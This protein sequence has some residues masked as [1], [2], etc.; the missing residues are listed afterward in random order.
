MYVFAVLLA[1]TWSRPRMRRSLQQLLRDCRPRFPGIVASVVSWFAIACCHRATC[2]RLRG[3]S[4]ASRSQNF[5]RGWA[6]SHFSIFLSSPSL[7]IPGIHVDNSPLHQL[8]VYRGLHSR[9]CFGC[10]SKNRE[11]FPLLRAEDM[12]QTQSRLGLAL[13][14]SARSSSLRYSE[15]NLRWLLIV[16]PKEINKNCFQCIIDNHSWGNQATG[17]QLPMPCVFGD[18]MR[19]V[20][21]GTL[22]GYE[23]PLTS[24]IS[25]QCKRS[26]YCSGSHTAMT[27]RS[28][29]FRG[30]EGG[31]L[32]SR[33]CAVAG[34]Q[35]ARHQ[36]FAAA[37]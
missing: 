4:S 25:Y 8:H 17:Q 7:S 5:R 35:S 9:V 16:L 12:L 18:M 2:H 1:R 3:A 14:F 30:C 10:R 23:S 26:L 11:C 34:M 19:L 24:L 21:D 20:P 27:L 15:L 22:T 36:L 13:R 31:N 33:Y 6:P 29:R 28:P 32:F 37:R